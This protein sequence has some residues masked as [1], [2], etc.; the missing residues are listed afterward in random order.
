MVVR[1]S[2][3]ISCER[4]GEIEV[5]TFILG[6]ELGEAGVGEHGVANAADMAVACEGD[7]GDTT[8]E[9]FGGGGGAVVGEGIEGDVDVAVGQEVIAKRGGF[10]SKFE[11]ID[12]DA[13]AGS[14]A[15]DMGDGVGMAEGFVLDDQP[16][17]GDALEERGPGAE[18]VIT[19][20]GIGIEGAKDDGCVGRLLGAGN[21]I[22]VGRW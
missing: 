7:D 5:G 8:D 22:G 19:D 20:L 3:A 21:G 16:R 12:G 18:D 14:A 2:G 13:S 9:S 10:A 11:A 17:V 1:E 15:A 4:G 6:D